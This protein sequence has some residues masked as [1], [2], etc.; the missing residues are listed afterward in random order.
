MISVAQVG[1]LLILKLLSQD[2]EHRPQ[3]SGDLR[4]LLLVASTPER[5]RM[6]GAAALITHRGYH[7]GR[8]LAGAIEALLAGRP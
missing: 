6:R 7:R 1:H 2:D 4:A 5:E 3:D 8:D